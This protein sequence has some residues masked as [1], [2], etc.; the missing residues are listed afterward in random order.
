MD[1][2]LDRYCGSVEAAERQVQVDALD[3]L[4]ALHAQQRHAR[5]LH[6]LLLLLDGPQVLAADAVRGLVVLQRLLLVRD[7]LAEQ[8]HA[9]RED[10]RGGKRVLHFVDATQHLACVACERFLLF[11]GAHRDLGGQR[12]ARVQRRK[13]RSARA[14][15]RVIE[16]LL[17]L[18]HVAFERRDA[19]IQPD[20]WQSGGLGLA[21]AI[22][23]R[24]DPSL[25]RDDVRPALEHVERHADRN[26][27]GECRQGRRRLQL[28]GRI[29][30]QQH[31]E[32][33]QRLLVGEARLLDGV[34]ERSEVRARQ[35]DVLLA[36]H[37]DLLPVLCEPQQLS[38]RLCHG[39]GGGQLQFRLGGHEP[40]ARHLRGHRLACELVVRPGR[41]VGR[42]RRIAP[43]SQPAPEIRFPGDAE[44]H[45][46]QRG[47]EVGAATHL[48]AAGAEQVDRW[49]QG[50]ARNLCIRRGL[51]HAGRRCAQVR[52]ACDR[53]VDELI[54]L[55]VVERSQPVVADGAC[56]RSD[57]APRG[58]D[59]RALQRVLADLL[60]RG[61]RRNG[62]AGQHGQDRGRDKD[63]PGARV[64]QCSLRTSQSS[65]APTR[66]KTLRR[67][68]IAWPLFV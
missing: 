45:A 43:V 19:G 23:G 47:G 6:L 9:L 63:V 13:Q 65:L 59:L 22:E 53:F 3:Q 57:G 10:L 36:A 17:Q 12:P 28:R 48:Q 62:A 21:D 52:V 2:L 35:R 44:H 14:A 61:R 29:T 37:A 39:L 1:R 4:L 15:G 38:R 32:R 30:T 58:A 25:G 51:L 11:R 46:L 33:A 66:M 64:H 26:R 54:E 42:I 18:D 49:Q 50:G 56:L 67:M 5:R 24:R 7:H 55:R 8:L 31:L 34:L 68:W 60:D 40:A 16:V 27:A 41:R 20:A